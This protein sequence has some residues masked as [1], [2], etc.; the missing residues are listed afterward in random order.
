MADGIKRCP[1]ASK[2]VRM[3]VV[4]E[5]YESSQPDYGQALLHD[6]RQGIPGGSI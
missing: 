1:T 2:G 3:M 5:C 4:E 6:L